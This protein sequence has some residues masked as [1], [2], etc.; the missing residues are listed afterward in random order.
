MFILS[1]GWT[2]KT[3][4]VNNLHR[5]SPFFY[6]VQNNIPQQNQY[7]KTVSTRCIIHV[8]TTLFEE[9]QHNETDLS[10]GVH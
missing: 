7:K 10:H 5:S 2:K 4:S 1:T 9:R 3:T 6:R 8:P